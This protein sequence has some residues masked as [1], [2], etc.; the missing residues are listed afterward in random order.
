MV[1]GPVKFAPLVFYEEFN[2]LKLRVTGPVKSAPLVFYEEFN[3][4]KLRVSSYGL[5][6]ER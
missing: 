3:G 5:S 1:R 2:R 6:C 4:L